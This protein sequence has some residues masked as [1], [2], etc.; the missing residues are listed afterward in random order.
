[1]K[2]SKKIAL[3][4]SGVLADVSADK[5]EH[6][7]ASDHELVPPKADAKRFVEWARKQGHEVYIVS[8]DPMGKP[9]L[10]GAIMRWLKRYYFI[11]PTMIRDR[12]VH[13]TTSPDRQL[14]LAR[15]LCVDIII[16]PSTELIEEARAAQIEA[17]HFGPSAD[18]KS[19][20]GL[21]IYL[22]QTDS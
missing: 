6:L 7:L 4:I 10:E 13:F 21:M 14:N 9:A 1:M 22:S 15:A 8:C 12:D 5:I 18:L 2:M 19:F 16:D 11:G 17:I 20:S 3:T